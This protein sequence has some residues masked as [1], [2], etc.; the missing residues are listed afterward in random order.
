MKIFGKKGIEK[1]FRFNQ[2]A[3]DGFDDYIFGQTKEPVSELKYG[4]LNKKISSVGCG[5]AAIYNVMRCIG[6]SQSFAEVLM[7]AELL[8]LPF[9]GGFFGTKTKKLG[10]YF[11]LHGV[12]FTKFRSCQKFKE[13]LPD[14]KIAI[15]C[16]WNDKITDGIHFYCVV[17]DGEDKYNSINYYSSDCMREFSPD[18]IRDDRFIIAYCF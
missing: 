8:R 4:S 14:C 6:D 10:R 2:D 1:R 18:A 11:K 3:A 7:D 15:V 13:S 16:S 17:P 5:V 9:C 12:N